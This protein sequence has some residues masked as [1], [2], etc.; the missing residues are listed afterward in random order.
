MDSE[1]ILIFRLGSLGDTV[2]ALPC[3]H[4]VARA[5]P[6]AEL[7]VCTNF[8]VS[9]KAPP[10]GTVLD[11]SGL[12]RGYLEY[13]VGSRGIRD[14]L[15]LRRR[16]MQL[17]PRALIY[18]PGLRNRLRTWRD[19]LFFK[20]CGIKQLIG[21][22]YRRDERQNLWL[23]DQHR[24]E[25]EAERLARCL[26][27]LGDARLNEP[28]SWDLR[29]TLN[30]RERARQ[31]LAAWPAPRHFI[32][33]A[34]GG[35]SEVQDWG[36]DN[37]LS[38][39]GHLGSR[40][41]DYGLLLIGAT[42]EFDRAS[43]LCRRWPGPRL[44]LCGTLTPRESAAVMSSATLFL[45]H[46]SGPM[47]LAAAVG[48]S[49]VAVFC[50]HDKPGVWFPWGSGNRV[51]Y[52]QTECF[53]CGLTVCTKYAKKCISSITVEEVSSAATELLASAATLR[54]EQAEPATARPLKLYSAAIGTYRR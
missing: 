53:G 39:I 20:A 3:F 38:L 23:S 9:H 15:A 26:N 5:F 34:V 24:Y 31:I 44:N 51:I 37:W 8:P 40:W 52:H 4:L 28:A 12:I 22:T 21:V 11:G 30:E 1:N 42:D 32:A 18:L 41:P 46:D 43:E 45:G 36:R 50:A 10:L 13:P 2:A 16:I 17:R 35:K 49:C 54:A 6:R 47:H 25:N 27:S 7:W 48:V 29:L 19:A 14:V 33:C